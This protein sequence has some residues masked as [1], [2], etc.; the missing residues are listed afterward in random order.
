[1]NIHL[2]LTV[3]ARILLPLAIVLAVG[4]SPIPIDALEDFQGVNAALQAKNYQQASD[5]LKQ[6]A[7]RFPWRAGLWEEAG[8]AAVAAGDLESGIGALKTAERAGVLSLEG[9]IMLGDAY[10]ASGNLR[11]AIETWQQSL[12]RDG[13]PV[14]GLHLRIAKAQRSLENYNLASQS[15]RAAVRL[16][17]E[18]AKAAYELG[19]LL[20]ADEPES[21]LAYLA[22]AAESNP[23][24]R[25]GSAAIKQGVEAA[26]MEGDPAY[27]LVSSGRAL[28]NLGEWELA[29]EAFHKA[30]QLRPDYAEGWAFLGHARQQIGE[31][32][33]V[34][35]DNSLRLNPTSV[36]ANTFMALYWQEKEEMGLALASYYAAAQA[37]P[38]N[39]NLQIDI[40]LTLASM[41]DLINAQSHF[42][43]A[44]L[45]AKQ[46]AEIWR[47][48]VSFALQ[49]NFQVR[50]MALP[51]AR[52]AVLLEPDNPASLDSI[53]Q[54]Y[55]R[56]ENLV[57]ARR[58]LLQAVQKDPGYAPAYLHLGLIDLL[59]QDY[60]AAYQRLTLARDLAP[61][62][63]TAQQAERFLN[64]NWR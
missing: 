8:Q 58:F 11:A 36:S 23:E 3:L 17:P 6:L 33:R 62:S 31:D 29:K 20:A 12:E 52:Q 53:G 47:M 51:A 38:E 22:Q 1:M 7:E 35:L 48:L 49:Y 64:D 2:D 42:R 34:A 10:K 43:Q 61:N 26:R 63:F 39:P 32:G 56:M 37:A 28:A 9:K 21:A 4:L 18:N 60:S 14:G 41:G 40:G 45:L 5:L 16:Q 59:N 24:Y 50:E 15:L 55:L 46:D 25:A 57:I 19:L 27:L 54:V 13:A 44:A 30:T